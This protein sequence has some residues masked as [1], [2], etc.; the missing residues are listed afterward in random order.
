MMA[1]INSAAAARSICESV[2]GVRTCSG[3]CHRN[4]QSL[5]LSKSPAATR[6]P[7]RLGDTPPAMT[8]LRQLRQPVGRLGLLLDLQRVIEL[9]EKAAERDAQCQFDDL[10]LAK[11]PAQPVKQALAN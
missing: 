10:R 5:T 7:R 8:G 1:A 3:T 11:M 9:V 2:I 4:R 6:F